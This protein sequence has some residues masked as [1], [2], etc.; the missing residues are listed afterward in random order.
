MGMSFF[1]YVMEST[2]ALGKS[3]RRLL[4]T[5]RE[6]AEL[7]EHP[8]PAGITFRFLEEQA[9]IRAREYSLGAGKVS[10]WSQAKTA[11]LAHVVDDTLMPR[12]IAERVLLNEY[13]RPHLCAVVG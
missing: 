8:N 13:L 10:E 1:P 2:G 12:G 11:S 9:C 3:T 4:K 5:I 7:R 6:G